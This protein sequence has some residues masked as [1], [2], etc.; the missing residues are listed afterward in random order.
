MAVLLFPGLIPPESLRFTE[1]SSRSFRTS[2]IS[3]ETSVEYFLVRF[4]PVD[5]LTGE[6]VSVS[7]PGDTHTVMLPHLTPLT[8]Y[9]V[10]VYA[11]YDMGDSFP[12]TGEE[13]TLDG[14]A[15]AP[16]VMGYWDT[17]HNH[18]GT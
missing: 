1:V 4:K 3:S 8:K 11:Q 10:N 5:D 13:T 2:W 17:E 9:E 7:V 18:I 15:R 14:E 6:Y 16:P 12:L